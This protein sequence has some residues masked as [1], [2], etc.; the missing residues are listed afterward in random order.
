MAGADRDGVAR[1][2]TAHYG[3]AGSEWLGRCAVDMAQLVMLGCGL[4]RPVR[5]GRDG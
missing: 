1:T 2:G 3:A 4:A 5:L